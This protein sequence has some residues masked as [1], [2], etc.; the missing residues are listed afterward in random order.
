MHDL[1]QTHEAAIIAELELLD[2]H[3]ERA[4]AVPMGVFGT[5]RVIRVPALALD[6]RQ[7]VVTWD[8]QELSVGVDEPLN[9]PWA[10]DPINVG[11]LSRDPLHSSSFEALKT[12][13]RPSR[14]T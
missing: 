5:L 14:F 11:V 4:L 3:V 10:G 9:Q 13:A 1:G 6:C 7:H 12:A 8:E 2:Q